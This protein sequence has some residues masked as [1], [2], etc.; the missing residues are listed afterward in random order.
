M[1]N[2]LEAHRHASNHRAEIESS[3]TCGCFN[4]LQIFKPDAI[5]AWT[6][7]DEADLADLEHAQGQTALCPHCGSESVVGDASG[8]RI[9]MEFLN[10]M[11][12]AWMQRTV[13]RRPAPRTK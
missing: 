13:I 1:I 3:T 12:Q 7:W 10:R 9:D 6:G 4:C 2:L 8:Y 5:I 11:N